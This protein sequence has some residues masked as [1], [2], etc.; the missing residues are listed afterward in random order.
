[1]LHPP[2]QQTGETF[3]D[4]VLVIERH[5]V[6]LAAEQLE[7]LSHEPPLRSIEKA[8][9]LTRIPRDARDRQARTLPHVVVVDL[10][11]RAGD[12]LRQLR[13]HRPQV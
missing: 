8:I 7:L 10:R 9:G 6:A 3:R 13:L 4:S 5:K 2:V 12:S 11:D 1:M